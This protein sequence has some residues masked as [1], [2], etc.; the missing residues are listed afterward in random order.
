M[1]RRMGIPSRYMGKT[2]DNLIGLESEKN[3]CKEAIL[4]NKSVFV[5]GGC[6]SGKTHMAI[7]LLI[8]WFKKY[9]PHK[10]SMDFPVFLPSVEFF[11][12]LKNTF[13]SD[14]S[15]RMILDKYTKPTLLCIDDVGAEKISDWSRQMFYVL[16]DRRYRD[17]KQTIITS[18]LALGRFS[19]LIDDRIASRIAGMG[20]VVYLNAE[21]YRLK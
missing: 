21:D 12:E 15:E 6:G 3:L 16:I 4:S 10:T 2:L 8:E 1:Q 9:A 14:D 5:A 7:G 13:G 11:L 20:E 19:E 18:N 17:E